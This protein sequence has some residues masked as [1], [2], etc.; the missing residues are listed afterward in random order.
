MK[1]N[2]SSIKSKLNLSISSF[3]LFLLLAVGFTLT[4]VINQKS[5]SLIINKAG[6]QR[7]LSQ[8]MS[9]ELLYSIVFMGEEEEN[10]IKNLVKTAS[11]FD[12]ALN[13]LIKGNKKLELPPTENET[14]LAQMNVV[15]EIWT[16]FKM[17]IDIVSS[18]QS[19]YLA[20]QNALDFIEQK[21]IILLTEMNKAVGLYADESQE[22]IT[23]L[24]TALSVIA[25]LTLL[26]GGWVSWQINKLI[27]NPIK[28]TVKSIKT[29]SD[30]DLSVRLK[31]K[32]T[33]ELGELAGTMN[34]FIS[35]L[36]HIMG[37][38][39]KHGDLINSSANNL[40]EVSTNLVQNINHTKEDTT[41]VSAATEEVSINVANMAATAEEMNINA[42]NVSNGARDVT[43]GANTVA[44]AVEE[45]SMSIN[46]VATNA[47]ETSEVANNGATMAKNAS[48][49]MELLGES[50]NE[51]GKVTDVIKR[52]AEQTNLL[53]LNAT[54]EAASAGEAGKG[55]AVVANEIKELANQSAQ[56]AE[57]I[58]TKIGGV[59]SNTN[60]AVEMIN[61][62]TKIVDTINE[63]VGLISQAVEQQSEA[64]ADISVSLNETQE[65]I[66]LIATNIA[67][68]SQGSDDL[69]KSTSE[70]SIAVN[71]V[72]KSIYEISKA[73]ESN[74]QD[75]L[76]V[77]NSVGD[78]SK[79]A[80]ELNEIV[81]QFKV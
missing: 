79:I 28:D 45:M 19:D 46:D 9:K 52:I 35:N 50:A 37:N 13:D 10:Y 21:N 67:E 49:T 51:I 16:E 72:T 14:T 75:A 60:I 47:R 29:I 17:N 55:F 68:V 56:A 73:T 70:S 64:A 57:D 54:I 41:D 34:S 78:F 66:S 39:K 71:D 63:S 62:V 77:K 5:D 18:P 12:K 22:R 74:N 59:Q 38:L 27:S 7:M 1:I 32:S 40:E 69:A 42:A 58:A 25:F 80:I 30:G 81:N 26:L 24:I 76:K 6:R 61:D 2:F 33:D 15:K 44:S 36:Q 53:A 3:V 23:R 8:K 65:S 4:T 31:N 48:A 11:E 20:H 43:D